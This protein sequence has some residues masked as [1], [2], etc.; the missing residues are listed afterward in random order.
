MHE[1]IIRTLELEAPVQPIFESLLTI[2]KEI[3]KISDASQKEIKLRQFEFQL[4]SELG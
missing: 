3:E 4:I 2:L 1:I